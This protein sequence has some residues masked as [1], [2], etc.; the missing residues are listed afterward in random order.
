[1]NRNKNYFIVLL[2][3]IIGCMLSGC[4]KDGNLTEISVKKSSEELDNGFIADTIVSEYE[5]DQK[6]FI[7]KREVK[8]RK[9]DLVVQ[10]EVETITT[11]SD[12]V[13]N[14]DYRKETMNE[15]DQ[16]TVF[17]HESITNEE[18]QVTEQMEE[19]KSTNKDGSSFYEK[20]I[21][22]FAENGE[23]TRTV[24]T[25]TVDENGKSKKWK[26]TVITDANG[27]IISQKE[28]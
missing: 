5:G 25:E 10:N 8:T 12:G 2:I 9:G 17:I 18:E 13:V 19:T 1:M 4:A 27:K 22:T 20:T 23:I 15:E 6:E 14:I 11:Y 21:Y 24:E 28:E 26:T 16:S 7:E 3:L